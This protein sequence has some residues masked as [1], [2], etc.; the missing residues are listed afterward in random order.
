MAKLAAGRPADPVPPAAREIRPAQPGP[1]AA[2]PAVGK[3]AAAKPVVAKP[4][5]P[6]KPAPAAPAAAQPVAAAPVAPA[7][8]EAAKP[9]SLDSL[10]LPRPPEFAALTGE[11]VMSQ[12]LTMARAFGALQAKMLEH[13]CSELK[14]TLGEAETLARSD[15]ASEAIALQAKAVRRSYESYAEHL[16]EL[17]RIANAALRK[18]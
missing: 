2:K 10:P 15:S 1:A 14:A 5:E 12:A 4:A 9:A 8:K 3:P 16:K 18:G 11:T 6:P 13:A 7:G 17:A